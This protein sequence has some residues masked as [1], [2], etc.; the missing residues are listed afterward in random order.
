MRAS[1]LQLDHYYLEELHFALSERYGTET[2][3]EVPL[4]AQDVDVTVEAGQNPDNE[5]E[6]LFR[7]KIALND[8]DAKFPYEFSM[9]LLGYFMVD[10]DC[11]P[12]MREQLATINGPSILYGAARE[13]LAIASA[14]SR[15]V[16][17]FLPPVRFFGMTKEPPP[18]DDQ[19]A[20]PPAQVEAPST[21]RRPKKAVAKKR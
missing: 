1:N 10:E 15:Y 20:L 17:I 8:A 9:R 13:I 21:K 18:S 12:E 11:K 7:L 19:K 3:E 16:S 2:M 14:R 6:W 4:K 5:L